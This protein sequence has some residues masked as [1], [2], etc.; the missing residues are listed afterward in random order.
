MFYV[1]IKAFQRNL[2]PLGQNADAWNGTTSFYLFDIAIHDPVGLALIRKMRP[3][4][5]VCNERVIQSGLTKII[6]NSLL[7]PK[8]RVFIVDNNGSNCIKGVFFDNSRKATKNFV[9][10]INVATDDEKYGDVQQ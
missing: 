9:K 5:L 6:E 10:E 2:G 4:T 1:A 7:N 8:Y 3:C